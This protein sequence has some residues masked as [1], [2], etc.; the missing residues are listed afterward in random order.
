IRHEYADPAVRTAAEALIDVR[1]FAAQRYEAVV[2]AGPRARAA[3]ARAAAA[4]RF[5]H[6]RLERRPISG[7]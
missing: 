6:T 2:V 3:G 7:L 4:G 5:A 1:Y